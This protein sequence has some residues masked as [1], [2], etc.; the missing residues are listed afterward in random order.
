MCRI[1]RVKYMYKI[2]RKSK[3]MSSKYLC[4]NRCY[5]SGNG[6]KIFNWKE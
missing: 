1:V 2:P 4:R 6:H 5:L 3:S